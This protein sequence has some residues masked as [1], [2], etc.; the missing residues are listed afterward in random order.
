MKKI[1]F[2]FMMLICAVSLNAQDNDTKFVKE[3]FPVL[4][5]NIA[6]NAKEKWGTDFEMQKYTITKQCEAFMEFI[7]I[8]KS[9]GKYFTF[10]DKPFKDIMTDALNKWTGNTNKDCSTIKGSAFYACL[11]EDWEM[12]VHTMK[13]QMDAYLEL[14]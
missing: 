9:S 3:T 13:K 8:R 14:N 6:D 2:I 7:N 12:V 11:N 4:Y 10:P 5:Q 1:V